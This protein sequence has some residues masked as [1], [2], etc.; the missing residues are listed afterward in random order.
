MINLDNGPECNG[1]RSQ[2]LQR[3]TEFADLTGLCARRVYYPPYRSKYNAIELR[4]G[5]QAL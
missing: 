3:M 1:R 4:E 5:C 2:F